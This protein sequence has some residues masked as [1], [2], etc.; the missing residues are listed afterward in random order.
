MSG[1]H[2][3][4]GSCPRPGGCGRLTE[5]GSQGRVQKDGGHHAGEPQPGSLIGVEDACRESRS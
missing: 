1:N 3:E 4:S 2:A 5:E